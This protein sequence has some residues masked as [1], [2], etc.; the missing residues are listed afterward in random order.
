MIDRHDILRQEWCR[1][2]GQPVQVVWRKATLV[3]QEVELDPQAGDIAEQLQA[4]F[5]PRHIRFDVT[6]AVFKRLFVAE[7]KKKERWVILELS[8]HLISD[9]NITPIYQYGNTGVFVG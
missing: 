7:D 5:D 6:Q 1:K 3:V 9:Q 2:L 8:H 4:R